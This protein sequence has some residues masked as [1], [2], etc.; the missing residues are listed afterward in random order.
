M[1]ESKISYRALYDAADTG[2]VNFIMSVVDQT[3]YKKLEYADMFYTNVTAQQLL[4][5][6]K[7]HCTGIHSIDTVD[8][9]S[10]MQTFWTNYEG[11]PQ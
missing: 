6:L 11:V 7:D 2:C 1:H 10:I 4:E 5:N 8:I 9:P 3:W